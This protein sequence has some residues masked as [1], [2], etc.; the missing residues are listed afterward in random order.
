[1]LSRL[2]DAREGAAERQFDRVAR[3]VERPVLPMGREG[4]LHQ[5]DS[6]V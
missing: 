6:T 2:L 3:V 1:M 4:E 5:C